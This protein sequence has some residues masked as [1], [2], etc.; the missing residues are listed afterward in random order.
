[1]LSNLLFFNHRVRATNTQLGQEETSSYRYLEVYGDEGFNTPDVPPAIV[2]APKDTRIVKGASVT[3]LQCIAN[4][5]PLEDLEI[6]WLKDGRPLEE[7]GVGFNFNDLWNR[8]LS[9]IGA[10]ESYAGVY[11]CQAGLRTGGPRVSEEAVVTITGKG[12]PVCTQW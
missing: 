8:T 4:A 11:T 12:K 10:E 3:E 9:L 2:I 7:S 6:T 1:M 5:R